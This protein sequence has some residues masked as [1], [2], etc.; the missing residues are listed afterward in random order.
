MKIR[1][2]SQEC[3]R[4]GGTGE[5]MYLRGHGSKCFACQG[6]CMELS[7]AGKRARNALEALLDERCGV[8]VTKIVPGDG[9]YLT[10]GS[11]K[12]GWYVVETSKKGS[13]FWHIGFKGNSSYAFQMSDSIRVYNKEAIQECAREVAK[14][15]SGVT[16]TD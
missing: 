4:C 15:F 11:A 6:S 13:E 7:P 3:S 2:E 8:S 10:K 1:Y 16:L 9:V 5:Y 12:P 14:N